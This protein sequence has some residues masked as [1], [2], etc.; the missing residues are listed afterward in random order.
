MANA[1]ICKQ[2]AMQ[3]ILKSAKKWV[4]YGLF[5]YF[6][7]HTILQVYKGLIFQARV[8][9]LVLNFK[10][11][12]FQLLLKGHLDILIR[13]RVMNLFWRNFEKLPKT[14]V[15]ACFLTVFRLWTKKFWHY[16]LHTSVAYFSDYLQCMLQRGTISIDRISHSVLMKISNFLKFSKKIVVFRR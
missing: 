6:L 13:S 10:K 4:S 16:E 1:S 5:T 11:R 3:R 9:K 2:C 15:F 12:L 14:A 8:M 7:R